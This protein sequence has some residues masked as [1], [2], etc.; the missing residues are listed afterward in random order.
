MGNTATFTS[1][2][3]SGSSS[4]VA[5]PKNI[6]NEY[7]EMGLVAGEARLIG[8]KNASYKKRLFRVFSERANSTYRGLVNGITR[9]LGFE[10]YKAIQINFDETGGAFDAP[11]PAVVINEAFVYLYSDVDAGT[12]DKKIDRFDKTGTA[13][14]L[15][16]LV[17]EINASTYFTASVSSGA[18]AYSQSMC[19]LNQKSHTQIVDEVVPESKNFSLENKNVIKG[20]LFF[21][22]RVRFA[23]EVLSEGAVNASG[24]YFVDYKKGVV[25]TFGGSVPGTRARYEYVQAP[26]TCIASPVIIHNMQDQD[27]KVKM[28][29]QVLADDNTFVNGLPTPL[30]ADLINELLTVFP[31]YWGK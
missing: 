20:S 8:E 22:D 11:N 1:P 18:D 26:M 15:T 5:L 21:S 19:I 12:I 14:N 10:F 3:V 17:A 24:K 31:G 28:F 6:F 4:G 25:F 7:D 13:W 16:N 23:T 29:E 2:L 9:G 27:F 30:G